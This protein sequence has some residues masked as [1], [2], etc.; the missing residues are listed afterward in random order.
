MKAEYSRSSWARRAVLLV[1]AIGVIPTWGNTKKTAY[2]KGVER[3]Q[4]PVLAL[5]HAREWQELEA[6]LDAE[7]EAPKFDERGLAYLKLYSDCLLYTS[8][9]PRDGA[10]SRMPSSA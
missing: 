10:T 5:F 9:S 2:T 3:K 4:A 6:L 7:L 8:P 1:I